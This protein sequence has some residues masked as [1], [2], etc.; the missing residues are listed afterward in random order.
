MYQTVVVPALN[1]TPSTEEVPLVTV[2]PVVLYVTVSPEQ[3]SDVVGAV[4][5]NDS[6]SHIVIPGRHE[7]VGAWLST[8]VTT[9]EQVSS[10]PLLSAANVFI[11]VPIGKVD[12]LGKPAI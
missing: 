7:T 2:A 9:K 1:T 5:D 10:P 6:P 4:D 8:T 12:P 11:V 3:L